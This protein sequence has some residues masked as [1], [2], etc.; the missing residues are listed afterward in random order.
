MLV[1]LLVMLRWC[2]TEALQPM[3]PLQRLESSR[4]IA[5]VAVDPAR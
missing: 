4:H 5:V 2:W 1:W 3:L